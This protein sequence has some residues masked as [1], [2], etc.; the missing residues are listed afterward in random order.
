MTKHRIWQGLV[1]AAVLGT[2]VMNALAN[3]VPFNGQQTG[4]VSDKYPVLFVPA[5]YV[6]SIWGVIYAGLIGYAVFQA[7]PAQG[8]NPRLQRIR[9]W[10]LPN[11]VANSIWLLLFHFELLALSVAVITFMLLSLI[12]I[13]LR[14]EVG[15]TAVST[16][17]RWLAH[18][19]FT[20]YLAWLTV[21]TI[22]NISVWLYSLQ[23]SGLGLSAAAWTNTLLVVATAISVALSLKNRDAVFITVPLWAFVGIAVK[24]AAVPSVAFTAA[25]MAGVT[26]LT[27]VVIVARAFGR[28]KRL[29]PRLT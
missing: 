19:P 16:A 22:A 29:T 20:L 7:L 5:G 3:I 15:R 27:C 14:L 9:G 12:V 26:A 2:I 25:T 10:V 18:V 1:V 6:F 8:A 11:L 24:Q 13:Y 4:D 21:A 23:W 28:R 17:E